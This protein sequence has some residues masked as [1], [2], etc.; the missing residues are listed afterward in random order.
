MK[1]LQHKTV[2][3]SSKKLHTAMELTGA[4]HQIDAVGS[5]ENPIDVSK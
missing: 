3:K 2:K 4:S 5:D 1:L